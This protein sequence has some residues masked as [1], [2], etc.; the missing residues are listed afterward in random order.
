[1]RLSAVCV[2]DP[3]VGIV[4]Y[5][6]IKYNIWLHCQFTIDLIVEFRFME[7]VNFSKVPIIWPL[8]VTWIVSIMSSIGPVECPLSNK[9][10][11]KLDL[12]FPCL[13]S[14]K[15]SWNLIL[16]DLPVC[17]MYFLLHVGQVNW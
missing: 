6:D 11:T 7:D 9:C 1:V 4:A 3:S 17:P 14:L 5:Y 16:K 12:L 2:G 10:W 15:C 8:F 13:K